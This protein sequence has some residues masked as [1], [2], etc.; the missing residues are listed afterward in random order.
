[1]IA[2]RMVV[3][4]QREG[5]QR[6]YVDQPIPGCTDDGMADVLDW[7]VA[8]LRGEHTVRSLARR[9]RMS[10]R[11]FARRF[12][13]ET[14]TTPHRWLTRQRVLRAQQLLEGTDLGVDDVAEESGFGSGALLRHHFR[15]VIGIAPGDY[16][17]AFTAGTALR[18]AATP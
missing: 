16:R 15:K 1:M 10:E 11:T 14:G 18:A 2:R 6:Q 8:N 5:G 3:P 12:L 13:A 4:P 7:A 9:A 17:R